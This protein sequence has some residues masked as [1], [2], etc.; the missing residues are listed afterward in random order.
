MISFFMSVCFDCIISQHVMCY[1]MY[2]ST[3]ETNDHI[4]SL[5]HI[6]YAQNRK[7]HD[8]P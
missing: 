4:I 1:V 2:A 5:L 8:N 6:V 7:E 3:V